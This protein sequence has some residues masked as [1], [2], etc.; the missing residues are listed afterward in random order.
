[1]LE[2]GEVAEEGRHEDL[3]RRAGGLYSRLHELQFAPEG[4]AV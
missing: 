4:Q 3:L 2:G 1:V